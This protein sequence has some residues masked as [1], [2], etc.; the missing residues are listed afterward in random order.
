MV[1]SGGVVG[2]GASLGGEGEGD[3]VA[4]WL[5]EDDLGLV[6]GGGGVLEL[7]DVEA[8]LLLDVLADN[9]GDGDLL[10]DA[11]L[12]GLG[13]GDVDGDLKGLGHQ[14]DLEALGLVLLVAV[15]VLAGTVV[16]LAVTG[17][18]AGGHLHGLGLGLIGH[19]QQQNNPLFALLFY[20][21]NNYLLL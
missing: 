1:W 2:L 6:D 11:H 12:L 7:G 14:R 16:G 19:L 9:L 4:V 17:R 10:L 18:L 21:D 3:V 5:S 20:L 13:S 8:L 15:L